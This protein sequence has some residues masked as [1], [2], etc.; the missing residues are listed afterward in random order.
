LTIGTTTVT[1]ALINTAALNVV[2]QVNTATFFATTSANVGANVQLTTSQ[3]FIGNSTVN[4]AVNSSALYVGNS[5]SNVVIT[6]NSNAKGNRTIL[7]AN[8]TNIPPTGGAVGDI[9]YY[10]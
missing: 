4:A 5:T 10:Y 3:L 1:T 8:A 9:Y 6:A 7:S 2:N